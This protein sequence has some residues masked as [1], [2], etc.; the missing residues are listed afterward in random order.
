LLSPVVFS[1]SASKPLAVFL[2]P[3]VLFSSA[4]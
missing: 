3:V 1:M 4:P 2:P